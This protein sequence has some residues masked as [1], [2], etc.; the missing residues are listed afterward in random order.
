MRA[1]GASFAVRRC[2]LGWHEFFVDVA[3]AGP[4]CKDA[5]DDKRALSSRRGHRS[6]RRR[7]VA[8]ELHCVQHVAN[9]PH[10]G[11]EIVVFVGGDVV[12][13][14][15][16]EG[17]QRLYVWLRAVVFQ[18]DLDGV[19]LGLRLDGRGAQVYDL[20]VT[21]HS[22]R[23]LVCWG[24][25]DVRQHARDGRVKRFIGTGIRKAIAEGR[26][27]EVE[28]TLEG[29]LDEIVRLPPALLL[30]DATGM[31]RLVGDGARM[32]E[33]VTPL[34]WGISVLLIAVPI[35]AARLAAMREHARDECTE[36]A[37]IRGVA[38]GMRICG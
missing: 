7:R 6:Q 35:E 20:G 36:H 8:L 21:A 10:A 16:D 33:G 3:C 2:A 14:P 9:L 34:L 18:P 17:G 5:L 37:G 1:R 4:V 31:R 32:L 23:E 27:R 12:L 22:R 13:R 19:D 15:F 29:D 28:R 26:L 24:V 30:R 38:E 25:E 11:S